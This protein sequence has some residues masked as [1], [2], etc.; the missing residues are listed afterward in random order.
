MFVKYISIK[1]EMKFCNII[2]I[3]LM[4]VQ[5]DVQN[6]WYIEMIYVDWKKGR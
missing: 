1:F 5:G 2:I 3:S 6:N 4:S